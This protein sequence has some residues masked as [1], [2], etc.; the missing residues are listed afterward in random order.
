MAPP[1]MVYCQIVG[2]S[3]TTSICADKQGDKPCMGCKAPSRVCNRCK[4]QP[5]SDATS[6]LCQSCIPTSRRRG[7][8]KGLHRSPAD[9]LA[10]TEAIFSGTFTSASVPA[11]AATTRTIPLSRQIMTELTP[12]PILTSVPEKIEIESVLIDERQARRNEYIKRKVY[13]RWW[14][15]V[16]LK[17]SARIL[18]AMDIHPYKPTAVIPHPK[19]VSNYLSCNAWV[20]MLIDACADYVTWHGTEVGLVVNF[21]DAIPLPAP[22]LQFYLCDERVILLSN[23]RQVHKSSKHLLVF[24]TGHKAEMFWLVMADRSFARMLSRF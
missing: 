4:S 21:A 23:R 16:A 15:S 19:L 5:V 7:K 17:N 11:Q 22:L 3:I 1:R 13:R 14:Q 24:E 12:V 9:L 18:G 10:R 8:S 20:E 2:G 6:G